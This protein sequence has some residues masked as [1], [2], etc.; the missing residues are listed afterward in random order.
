M[1][2]QQIPL[3]L[4]DFEIFST[5]MDC[6]QALNDQ[7]NNEYDSLSKC[8][9]LCTLNEYVFLPSEHDRIQVFLQS[10]IQLLSDLY[11]YAQ[12]NT[13]EKL[14]VDSNFERYKSLLGSQSKSEFCLRIFQKLKSNF[15]FA[16][17]KQ[18]NNFNILEMQDMLILDPKQLID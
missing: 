12:F 2:I 13:Q 8:V 3:I 11:L 17:I 1:Y 7:L 18:S 10:Y 9:K 14:Q 15:T 5:L 4:K 6:I 16:K